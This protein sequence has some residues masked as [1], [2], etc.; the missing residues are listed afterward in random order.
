[1]LAQGE[2]GVRVRVLPRVGT[3]PLDGNVP[4]PRSIRDTLQGAIGAEESD[5]EQFASL[6]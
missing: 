6:L 2:Q 1:M 4:G 5:K 3:R